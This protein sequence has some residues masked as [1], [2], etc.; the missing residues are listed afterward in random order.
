M[1]F[2]SR[3]LYFIV[4]ASY[5]LAYPHLKTRPTVPLLYHEMRFSP[6]TLV[7]L[8]AVLCTSHC[9]ESFAPLAPSSSIRT[10]S[11]LRSEDSDSNNEPSS[12][13]R[14]N[15]NNNNNSNTN[16]W[17]R[18]RMPSSKL[19]KVK[20][21]RLV[22]FTLATMAWWKGP[23][24]I[25]MTTQ[26]PSSNVAHA[27]TPTTA[28][29]K[30][31]TKSGGTRL[32]TG[33]GTILVA[34]GA[35]G[36]VGRRIIK[37]QQ[38][39]N[40]KVNGSIYDDDDD[41][42]IDDQPTLE[43]AKLKM[44][45]EEQEAAETA[46]EEAQEK[47]QAM[48]VGMLDRVKE[49]QNRASEMLEDATKSEPEPPVPPPHTPLPSRP[50]PVPITNADTAKSESQTPVPRTPLPSRPVPVP[51]TNDV[52]PKKSVKPE[53]AV[54]VAAPAVP[55]AMA[56][57]AVPIGIPAA[58]P[59]AAKVETP[60][61]APAQKV[62]VQ[63]NLGWM[64][65]PKEAPAPAPVKIETPAPAPAA[66]ETPAPAK[67]ETPAPAPVA[68][69]APAPTK[70]ETPAPVAKKTPASAPVKTETPAPE[71]KVPV[72]SSSGWMP[73]TLQR[74]PAPAPTAKET[75]A[76]AV[77]KAPAP[78]AE[79]APVQTMMSRSTPP[80]DAPAVVRNKQQPKPPTEEEML[81]KKYGSIES[82]EERAYQI[83]LD[84]GMV[85]KTGSDD[86]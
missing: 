35:G 4:V 57:P 30:A 48:V 17:S 6:S 24:A 43:F 45:D 29:R 60:A 31:S 16:I 8:L 2:A 46:A 49:A 32:L 81:M 79:K 65:K 21:S 86:A 61:S 13:R 25:L 71:K 1:A 84:L 27:A 80:P 26:A 10:A 44:T 5:R 70:I 74:A 64:P 40:D 63:S 41:N 23:D 9:V 38:G 72:Q 77:E 22:G 18:I 68:K 82:L 7:T 59:E 54:V 52:E 66:K 37:G 20:R 51:I 56:T 67:I 55:S 78:A 42:I 47:A 83:L 3:S 53:P 58:V 15:N 33:T 34:A 85:E 69:K 76:P 28:S 73:K 14:I 19:H 39:K 50:V 11:S 36:M 75:P 12:S 62:P